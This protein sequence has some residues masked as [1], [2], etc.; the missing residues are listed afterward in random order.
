MKGEENLKFFFNILSEIRE[1]F[2]SRKSGHRTENKKR[3]LRNQ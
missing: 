2:T 3:A 1:E